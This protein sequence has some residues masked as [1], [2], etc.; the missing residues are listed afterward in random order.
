MGVTPP[1]TENPFVDLTAYDHIKAP[2]SSV[3]SSVVKSST[4]RY[5][6][7]A[8]IEI[9]DGSQAEP[10]IQVQR[11]GDRV[12]KIEFICPCGKSAHLDLEYVEE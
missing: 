6:G 3:K 7:V 5:N 10:A 1:G 9:I 2:L 8:K 12:K 11:E 4:I